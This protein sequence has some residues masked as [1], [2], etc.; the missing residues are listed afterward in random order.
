[1]YLFGLIADV[2]C[3]WFSTVQQT[4]NVSFFQLSD[5]GNVANYMVT[6]TRQRMLNLLTYVFLGTNIFILRFIGRL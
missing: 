5:F 4:I 1:M 6:S 3:V 2:L